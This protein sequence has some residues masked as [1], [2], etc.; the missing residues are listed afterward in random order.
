MSEKRFENQVAMITGA[1]GGIGRTIA[2]SF[3]R[4][5]AILVL[6]DVD[7]RALGNLVSSLRKQEVQVVSCRMDV[8]KEAEVAR[9]VGKILEDVGGVDIL[10]NN[11]GVSTMNWFWELTEEEWDFNMNVNAKGVWLVTKYVVP[12][13]IRRRKGKIVNIASMAAKIGAP[14]LAHYSASKF[15]VVGFTQAAAKELAP[16]GINVNAVCPGFVKTPMQDREVIWEAQLRGIDDP[17][18]VRDEYIAQ[19]PLGRLCYPEDVA[20]VVLFLASKDADF[21]TGQAVNVTGGVC[22]H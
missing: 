21:M 13:M 15:A 10:V 4:E 12:H 17:E 11:A 22:T 3:A 20:S 7:E 6:T 5:G 1:G 9:V 19:T 18:K 16:Y 2:A 14:L 8:T